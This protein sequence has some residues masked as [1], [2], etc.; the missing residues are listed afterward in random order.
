MA[1]LSLV[2]SI[3]EMIEIKKNDFDF[4]YHKLSMRW[5]KEFSEFL[6]V[7]KENGDEIFFH[8]HPLNRNEARRLV[9]YQ[10]KDLYYIQVHKNKIVGYGML[11]GWDEGF[12]IPSLGIVVHPSVRRHG[13]GR[14]LLLFLHQTAKKSGASQEEETT[15]NTENGTG[16]IV[17]MA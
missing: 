15:H 10:G 16:T 5:L 14:K 8:P 11:R 2:T 4:T 17:G 6:D 1:W 3:G 9:N 13:N 7:L 12:D